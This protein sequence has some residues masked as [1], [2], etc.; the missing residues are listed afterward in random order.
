MSSVIA[1]TKKSAPPTNETVRTEMCTAR[2]LPP[3]TA[4][5]VQTAWPAMPPTTTPMPSIDDADTDVV[6]C[7]RSPH[8]AVNVIIKHCAKTGVMISEY[9][10]FAAAALRARRCFFSS[11]L[12]PVSASSPSDD[13]STRCRSRSSVCTSSSSSFGSLASM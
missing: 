9:Q 5:P 2:Y 4:S 8:S 3:R 7:D 12:S 6:I 11:T 13:S 1:K 10:G